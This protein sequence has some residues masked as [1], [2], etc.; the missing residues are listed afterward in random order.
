[1]EKVQNE[2]LK[3]EHK[4]IFAALSAFQGEN[5]EIKRTKEVKME[6]KTG[7]SINFWYAPLDE[8][9]QVVRPITSKQGLAFVWEDKDGKMVCAL[10]HETYSRVE[11][12][13]S[14]DVVGNDGEEVM[15]TKRSYKTVEINVI[16]SMPI[17]VRRAGD[18]KDIGTDSTYARRYTLAEVLGIA[19]DEDTDVAVEEAR[20]ENI[21]KFAITQ[22]KKRISEL[23]TVVEVVEKEK[24]FADEVK[25]L[26]EGKAPKLGFTLEQYME[27]A[28]ACIERKHQIGAKVGK[29]AVDIGK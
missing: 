27:L 8:V 17:T 28:Q 23:K 14:E 2:V 9:L 20:R 24:M 25:L 5:P 10:Y 15:L 7:R 1:M 18:M 26:D 16:R 6:L 13:I 21:E 29:E 22:A 12:K 4:N 3:I 19:S 11:E